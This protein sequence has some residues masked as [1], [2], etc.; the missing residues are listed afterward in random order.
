MTE[1]INGTNRLPG[2]IFLLIEI[3][4]VVEAQPQ[5]VPVFIAER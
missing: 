4:T 5:H 2:K 3:Q 1:R